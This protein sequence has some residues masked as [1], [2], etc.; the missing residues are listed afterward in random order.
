M[1]VNNIELGWLVG[2]FDG[3]GCISLTFERSSTGSVNISNKD[4]TIRERCTEIASKLNLPPGSDNP[5]NAC[6]TWSGCLGA[7]LL[8]KLLPHVCNTK[9]R[10]RAAIYLKFFDPKYRYKPQ[11]TRRL[12]LWEEWKELVRKEWRMGLNRGLKP[13]WL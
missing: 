6:I 3:E 1:E 8:E 13:Y 10:A 2:I 9:Q 11:R 5:S 12:Q 4:V 7:L